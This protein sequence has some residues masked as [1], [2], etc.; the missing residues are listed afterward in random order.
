MSQLLQVLSGPEDAEAFKGRWERSF[1]EFAELVHETYG[2][3]EAGPEQGGPAE[4][5][6]RRKKSQG[7]KKEAGQ[8]SSDGEPPLEWRGPFDRIPTD[9][10]EIAGHVLAPDL[11]P[12][13]ERVLDA[14]QR[15]AFVL[16]RCVCV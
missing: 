2:I 15:C 5:K 7:T 12:E 10:P 16:R 8:A 3:G 4:K 13:V 14:A 6:A 11:P 9:L 1:R